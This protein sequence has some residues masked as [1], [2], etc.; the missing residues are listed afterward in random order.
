MSLPRFVGELLEKI[1]RESLEYE[2][3]MRLYLA[4][5]PVALKSSRA[6]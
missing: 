1:M 2:R 4:R 5:E 6:R 3:A